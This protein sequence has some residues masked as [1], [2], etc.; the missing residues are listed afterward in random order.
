MLTATQAGEP[1]QAVLA[2]MFFPN[3]EQPKSI[4][5]KHSFIL[6]CN[7]N[8]VKSSF[9]SWEADPTVWMTLRKS[10]SFSAGKRLNFTGAAQK[11]TY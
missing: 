10:A 5:F 3:K 6:I 8:D 1:Q 4:T 7:Q 9:I 11:F 2:E